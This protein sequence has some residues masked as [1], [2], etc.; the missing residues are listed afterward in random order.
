[1]SCF[2]QPCYKASL[3]LLTFTSSNNSFG[4]TVKSKTVSTCFKM[5]SELKKNFIKGDDALKS[6]FP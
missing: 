5:H 6:V 1:M 2:Y 3:S 4:L